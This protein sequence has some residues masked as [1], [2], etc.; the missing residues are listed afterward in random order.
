MKD[1]KYENESDTRIILDYTNSIIDTLREPFL[2]LNEKLLVITANQAF[3]TY[4]KIEEKDTISQSFPDLG[5]KQWNIPK[6]LKLLKEI[7]PEKKVVRDYEIEIKFEHT[8]KRIMNLNACQLHVPKRIIAIITKMV[9]AEAVKSGEEKLILLAIE[10]I[11]V[12]KNVMKKLKESE[13]RFHKAFN[14]SRDILFLIHKTKGDIINSNVAA[15][16]S[17]GYSSD[18]FLKKKLWEIGLIRS[19]KEFQE[20]LIELEKEGIIHYKDT[21]IKTK[22]GLSIDTEAYLTDKTEVVQ[23]N[24]RDITNRKGEEEELKK[25]QARFKAIFEATMDGMLL[26]DI[27][28]KQFFMFNKAICQMLG[29]TEEEIIRL[30]IKDIHNDVDLPYVMKHFE[31]QARGEIR[32]ATGVPVKR[33]DGSIFY[34]DINTSQIILSR[35]R[36]LIESFRDITERKIMQDELKK[37]MQDLELFIVNLP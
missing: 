9:E 23:C 32:L 31:K 29:Y 37:K 11:T 28:T 3:Y 17:I 5:N 1:K 14:T 36:Y 2:V 15:T 24:I 7:L 16:K 21:L 22:E 8:G 19:K 18:E 26:A 27:E 35:K 20:M 33:K 25:S 13:Q 10:D 30:G 34:A 4:F 6:L 12:R